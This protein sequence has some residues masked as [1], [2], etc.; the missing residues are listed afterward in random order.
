MKKSNF[1]WIITGFFVCLLWFGCAQQKQ[2]AE[3]LARVNDYVLTVNDFEDE[4]QHS[5]YAGDETLGKEEFLDLMIRKQIL[6][7]EAQRQG[8]DRNESFMKTIER[9]W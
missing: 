6:I 7:Q 4:V 3:V 9:Y 5:P 2:G 1:L 8:L